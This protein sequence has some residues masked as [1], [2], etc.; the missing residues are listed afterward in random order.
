MESLTQEQDKLVQM[1]TIK[2]TKDQALTAGV[3]NPAK[4]KKKARDSKQQ[5]KKKQEKPKSLDGVSN[6]TKEKEKKKQEKTK[7]TYCHKGWHPE[8]ACMKKTI[9]MMA[10]LLDKNNIPLPEGAR[11]KEGGSGSKNKDICQALVFF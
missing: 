9:D 8:S 5:E 6:P 7:C 11:K 3:S 4:G 10:Q 2:S 1:C